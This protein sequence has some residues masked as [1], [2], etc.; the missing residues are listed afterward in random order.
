MEKE[1]LSYLTHS[2]FCTRGHIND[3]EP[4]SVCEGCFQNKK[5]QQH[6]KHSKLPAEQDEEHFLSSV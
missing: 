6:F 5:H 3:K 1:R 4:V 2:V